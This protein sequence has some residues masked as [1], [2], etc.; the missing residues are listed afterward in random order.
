MNE[1]LEQAE[2]G[3]KYFV[4]SSLVAVIFWLFQPVVYEERTLPLP[5]WYPF[6]Y[7]APFIYPLAY[8]LQVI[9]QLQLALTFVT[10][11]IYFTVLC[12][13]LCGQFDVLNCSLKNILATTYILMGASRKD[14]I[15]LREHQCNADD[16]INQYFVA[17]ELHINLDCIPHVLTPATTAGTMNFRDAFHCALGQCV[18]HHIFILNALRK[19]EKLFSMVWFF[20]TLEVTFAICT[21]AFDVVKSTDDKSFLQ[22]LSLGQYMILVLWE[23]FMI[24]YGGEI[25]YINSQR[26]D[27]A[28]LRSPWYLHSREMRAEILFFLLHAQRAFALTGGKFYPLKLEKFQ[29][30]L[31]TS[32]SFYTLL[33]NMDQRN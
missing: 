28:L 3:I 16:E 7:K 26:C 4:L 10:N 2:R 29:A 21:I 23:M 1:C 25:V 5:C 12:F 32:F 19:T 9:A 14:L 24:C 30:I 20:K 22:V 15:E 8:F 17:E 27:L 11:S 33:Q 18:D 13:L 6:D 31:T